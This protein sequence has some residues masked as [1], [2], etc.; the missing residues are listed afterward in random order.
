MMCDLVLEREW[1][2]NEVEEIRKAEVRKPE[3]LTAGEECRVSP[4]L[5]QAQAQQLPVVAVDSLQKGLQF[6]HM[7]PH[8]GDTA[9]ARTKRSNISGDYRNVWTIR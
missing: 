6:L 7:A 9:I 8:C 4:G 3:L 2:K 5:L 1:V